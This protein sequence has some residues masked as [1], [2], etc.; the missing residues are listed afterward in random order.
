[1]QEELNHKA[2][3]EEYA[4]NEIEARRKK[5]YSDPDAGSDRCFSE[6]ARLAAMGLMKESEAARLAGIARAIEIQNA[7]PKKHDDDKVS[8]DGVPRAIT[9]RQ[10]K[11]MLVEL[12]IYDAAESFIGEQEGDDKVR[13]LIGW[14]AAFAY[15]DDELI[16]SFAEKNGID[17]EDLDRWFL[18]ASK[19]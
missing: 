9:M 2:L 13:A 16:V 7:H 6:S 5:A 19:L 12:G 10:L 11:L 3:Y 1:M 8:W 15:R 4:K 14:S 18:N 17:S